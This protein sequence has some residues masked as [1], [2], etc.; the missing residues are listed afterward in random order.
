MYVC[1]QAF[2]SFV[3]LAF[4]PQIATFPRLHLARA[5]RALE[6]QKP[7][8]ADLRKKKLRT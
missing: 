6:D 8:P 1:I 7:D 2:S 3:F 4:G 5:R